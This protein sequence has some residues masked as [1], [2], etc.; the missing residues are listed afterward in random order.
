MEPVYLKGR[1]G[2]FGE[3]QKGNAPDVISGKG[4]YLDSPKTT[5]R[6]LVED[7]FPFFA[8]DIVLKAPLFVNTVNQELE[9]SKRFQLIDL[10]INDEHVAASMFDRRF[11]LSPYLKEGEDEWKVVLT[12][13]RRNKLGPFHSPSE[14]DMVTSPESFEVGSEETD[15]FYHFVSTIL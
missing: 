13:S 15:P 8:G 10:F 12:V 2:V 14:E 11:G 6:S 4:F 3:F 1:F 7:G 5:I 9:I